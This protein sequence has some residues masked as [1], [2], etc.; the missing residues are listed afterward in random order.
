[1]ICEPHQLACN[2]QAQLSDEQKNHNK[3]LARLASLESFMLR[4]EPFIKALELIQPPDQVNM[5]NERNP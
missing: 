1:M 5:T 2:S 4:A 3:I